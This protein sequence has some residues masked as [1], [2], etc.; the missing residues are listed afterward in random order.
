MYVHVLRVA[1]LEK[2]M[3]NGSLSRVID[4]VTYRLTIPEP[5]SA[6]ELHTSRSTIGLFSFRLFLCLVYY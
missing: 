1:E 2:S 3:P 5:K 6:L 4:S